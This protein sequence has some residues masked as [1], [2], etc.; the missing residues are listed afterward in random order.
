MTFSLEAELQ[1]IRAIEDDVERAQEYEDLLSAAIGMV[2]RGEVEAAVPVFESLSL[3]NDDEDDLLQ[4][5]PR[6]AKLYLEALGRRQPKPLDEIVAERVPEAVW[7]LPDGEKRNLAIAKSLY[8]YQYDRREVVE[9]ALAYLEKSGAC[10]TDRKARALEAEIKKALAG[11]L[12]IETL[13]LPNV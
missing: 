3:L 11:P 12:G 9:L 10:Q 8:G 5:V 13:N 6:P 7:N 4:C 1:R 2:E